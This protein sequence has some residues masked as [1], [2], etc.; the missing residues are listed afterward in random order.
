MASLSAAAAEC[1]TSERNGRDWTI[2]RRIFKSHIYLLI[3]HVTSLTRRHASTRYNRDVLR[4][5]CIV[6]QR[7]AE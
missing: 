1:D 4:S 7:F 5:R 6:V 3:L 2:L